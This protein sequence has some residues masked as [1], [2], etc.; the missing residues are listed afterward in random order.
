[1]SQPKWKFSNRP[2]KWVYST[3]REKNERKYLSSIYLL[4]KESEV[5]DFK[6][7]EN[8]IN[9]TSEWSQ[10]KKQKLSNQ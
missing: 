2:T 9:L 1:M 7:L 8:S 5:E 6:S 3:K 4:I 10:S